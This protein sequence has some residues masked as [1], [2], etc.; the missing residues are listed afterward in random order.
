M[1]S[2]LGIASVAV[3]AVGCRATGVAVGG[4]TITAT[5]TKGSET[6]SAGAEITVAPPPFPPLQVFFEPG[7]ITISQ[8]ETTEMVL[9]V[10]GGDP[11]ASTSWTCTAGDTDVA[12][13]AVT[14]TGCQV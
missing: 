6:T 2:N 14:T 11:G 1:S 9:M 12:L 13:V 10:L 8:S 3:T 5:V 4:A 7:S